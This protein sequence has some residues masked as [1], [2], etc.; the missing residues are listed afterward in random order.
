MT[1]FEV[2]NEI[3]LGN[4][5]WSSETGDTIILKNGVYG[6]IPIKD[7]LNQGPIL[8]SSVLMGSSPL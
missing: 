4:A 6:N 2:N 3:E 5:I 8:L 7:G 1:T